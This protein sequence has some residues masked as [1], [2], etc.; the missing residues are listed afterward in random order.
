MTTTL[1][2]NATLRIFERMLR[3]RRLEERVLD[4]SARK[5]VPGH[6]H[7]YI[8]QEAAGAA[9]LE[10]LGPDDLL[11]TTHRNHGHLAGRGSDPGRLLAEILGREGGLNRGRGG[12]L[13]ATDRSRGFLQT[14]ALVGGILPLAVGAGYAIKQARQRRV[15]VAFFGDGALEEGVAFESLN[16]AALWALPMIFVCE[17]NSVGAIGQQGGGYPS[18]ISAATQLARIPQVFGIRT[19][20]FRDGNDIAAIYAATCAAVARCAAG[21]GPVFIETVT[22]RWPGSQPLWPEPATGRT[23]LAMAWGAADPAGPHRDWIARHD[24]VLRV[25]REMLAAGVDRSAIESIDARIGA[26]LDAA[27]RYAVASPFPD[28]DGAAAGTFA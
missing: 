26:D 5:L 15:A 10:A 2:R 11:L 24:P 16:I 19:H 22:T 4:L 13:H 21:D 17:N 23:D 20:A 18:S 8:G 27:E 7:L 28:P 25:A 12:T 9:V 3:M 6:Y 14:S 1:D